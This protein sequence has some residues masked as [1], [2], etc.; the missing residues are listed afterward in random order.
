[1]PS[2]EFCS[3]QVQRS[4]SYCRLPPKDFGSLVLISML[5][6]EHE[7]EMRPAKPPRA[8]MRVADLFAGQACRRSNEKERSHAA[9]SV[10]AKK[11]AGFKEPCGFY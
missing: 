3:S 9:G 4:S 8:V 10:G 2:N 6:V 11:A 7:G 1:M 5:F